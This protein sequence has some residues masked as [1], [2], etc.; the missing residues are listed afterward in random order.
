MPA[1]FLCKHTP[2]GCRKA[3]ESYEQ[4]DKEAES[5]LHGLEVI[6]LPPPADW[7][8]QIKGLVPAQAAIGTGPL[9]EIF[10]AWTD[11]FGQESGRYAAKLR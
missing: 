1:V 3:L 2:S 8:Y 6:T 11:F 9:T 7:K 5:F 10:S 4:V